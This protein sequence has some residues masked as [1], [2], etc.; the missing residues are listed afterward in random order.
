MATPSCLRYQ[1][2]WS[3]VV[4]RCCIPVAWRAMQLERSDPAATDH[5]RDLQP[6][7]APLIAF[8]HSRCTVLDFGRC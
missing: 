4:S 3:S 2:I 1:M 5:Q 8:M 7:R 6:L